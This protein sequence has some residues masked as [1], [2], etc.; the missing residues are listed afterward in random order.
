MGPHSFP[1]GGLNN[2][3]KYIFT[4]R[5]RNRVNYSLPRSGPEMQP[6]GTPAAPG[7]P[8]A[9][10]LETGP[11]QTS[12]RVAWPST[13]PEGPGPTLYSV[14][15]ASNAGT[16]A[17][18]RMPEDHR[19]GVHPFRRELRRS[20]L[21]YTVVAYNQLAKRS[22]PSTPVLF[23]AV[24]RPAAVGRLVL[25]STGNDAES[26]A[27]LHRAGLPGRGQPGGDPR[28]RPG[29]QVFS[30]QT[31]T[32]IT[33]ILTP[34]NEQPY[35]VQLRV[36]NE[37]APA[38]CTLAARRTC[39]ATDR[40]AAGSTTSVPRRSTAGKSPGPSPAPATATPR[41]WPSGSTAAPSRS[42]TSAAW[43]LHPSR[44][45]TSRRLR[46][47][48]HI[49]VTLRDAAPAGRGADYRAARRTSGRPPP[50]PSVTIDQGPL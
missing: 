30:Q 20:D 46:R 44:S 45:T 23:E 11:N 42:S 36:C 41:D 29:H 50:P 16:T 49:E 43:V 35:Q 25:H 34:G 38:G 10:D 3:E 27:H 7:A 39:R 24:G 2:N 14:N 31:G 19:A 28:R 4:I 40:W 33:R 17:R 1:V 18:P 13:L 15:I 26:P 12:V 22:A 47:G 21:D 48:R 32:N 9:T 6:V 8:T 37:N 5:A